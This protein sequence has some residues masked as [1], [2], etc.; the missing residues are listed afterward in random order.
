MPNGYRESGVSIAAP[1]AGS[2]N[3]LFRTTQRVRRTVLVGLAQPTQHDSVYL[4]FPM[5][6]HAL[7]CY[8]VR[9]ELVVAVN[10][11]L[12]LPL[13][14]RRVQAVLSCGGTE[15]ADFTPNETE[16]SKY[17]LSKFWC[18]SGR[19]SKRPIQMHAIT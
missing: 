12:T 8:E 1:I 3:I 13:P 18:N 7:I 2:R 6:F 14:P 17:S 16:L 5:P 15:K 19:D 9:R 4:M 10:L 11:R